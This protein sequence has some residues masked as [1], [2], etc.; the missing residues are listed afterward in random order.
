MKTNQVMTRSMG[1]FRVEQRTSD[2]FFC[3]T[4]LLKQWNEHVRNEVKLNPHSNG[5]LKI[6]TLDNYLNINPSKDLIEAICSKEKL[7]NCKCVVKTTKGKYGGTWLH[8]VMFIDLCMWINTYF[9]YDAIK[10]VYDQMIFYRKESCE[11][12][13][14]LSSAVQSLVGKDRMRKYMPV[15]SN[16]VNNVVFGVSG[17][18]ERNKHGNEEQMR[19]LFVFQNMVA[20]VV[21]DGLV[22]T[23]DALMDYLRLKWR[24]KYVKSIV[25]K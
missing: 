7:P 15:V 19:E 23:F 5:V 16:A 11:A 22:T 20:S 9:K 12:Y 14:A 17:K 18:M 13:K 3:A 24:Q 25:E 4:S 6:K 8:P 2:G 1:S 21:N 10:F